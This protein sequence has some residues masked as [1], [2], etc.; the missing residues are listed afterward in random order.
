MIR[1]P[2]L[3]FSVPEHVAHRRPKLEKMGRDHRHRSIDAHKEQEILGDVINDVLC[4]LLGYTRAVDNLKRYA[5]S[6]EKHVQANG[7]FADAVLGGFGPD[8][9]PYVTAAEG[10]HAKGLHFR[11]GQPLQVNP[12]SMPYRTLFNFVPLHD[13]PGPFDLVTWSGELLGRSERSQDGGEDAGGGA[14][15][16]TRYAAMEAARWWIKAID[17]ELPARPP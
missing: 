7:K 12:S 17:Q 16:A 11:L 3:G 6:R 15:A 8:W 1:L 9:K 10:S 13:D 5:I 14:P 4:E 2:L